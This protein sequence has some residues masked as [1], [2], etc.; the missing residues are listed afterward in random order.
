MWAGQNQI[1]IKGCYNKSTHKTR[2]SKSRVLKFK[3]ETP[4]KALHGEK[5]LRAL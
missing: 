4:S 3:D 2:N 1:S 5:S